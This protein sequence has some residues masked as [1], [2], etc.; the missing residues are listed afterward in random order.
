MSLELISE[1]TVEEQY[2]LLEGLPVVYG[3][4]IIGHVLKYKKY[5][6]GD[7]EVN[8]KIKDTCENSVKESLFAAKIYL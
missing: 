7:I 3:N 2:Q 5:K 6:N 8:I 4:Y 1:I